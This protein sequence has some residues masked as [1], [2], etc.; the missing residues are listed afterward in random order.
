MQTLWSFCKGASRN[1]KGFLIWI[2]EVYIL[3]CKI[4][5]I[6]VINHHNLSNG[7]EGC[8]TEK[9]GIRELFTMEH[10][11]HKIAGQLLKSSIQVHKIDFAKDAT[12]IL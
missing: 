10:Q 1:I 5:A 6:I 2:V 9:N 7:Q 11:R 4:L 12:N 8:T 3:N